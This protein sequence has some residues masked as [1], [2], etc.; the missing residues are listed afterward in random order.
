MAQ[1]VQLLNN[2]LIEKCVGPWG[3]MIVLAQKPRQDHVTNID[4]FIW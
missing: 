3:S 1:I 2:G 4:D